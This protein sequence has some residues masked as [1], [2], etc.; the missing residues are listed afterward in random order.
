MKKTLL[1]DFIRYAKDEF[2]CDIHLKA[3][4]KPDTFESI[5]GVSFLNEE[6]NGQETDSFNN[7][8][9]YE[10]ISIKVNLVIDS[11]IDKEFNANIGLAA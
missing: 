10:N 8:L 7:D 11:E 9:C 2:D 3:S 6:E 1:D 4:D 5:F